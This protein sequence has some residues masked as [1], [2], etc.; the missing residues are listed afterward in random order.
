MNAQKK[1]MIGGQALKTLGNDR[2]TNDVDYLVNL[3]GKK[4]FLTNVEDGV[5]FINAAGEHKFYMEVWQSE[6]N[7]NGEIAS[8]QALLELKA[9]S[10]A[11]HCLNFNFAKADA[12]EYDI[13]FLVREFGV[14]K[15]RI[16]NK[17]MTKGE[18]FTVQQVIDSVQSR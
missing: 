5:D 3:P 15:L 7:N 13:K 10:F 9:F 18:L 4:T 6:A 11:Q 16:A 8:P 1:L 2:H 17:H 12:D 14:N